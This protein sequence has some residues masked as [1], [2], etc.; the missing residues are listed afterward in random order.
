MYYCPECGLQFEKPIKKYS[1][2]GFDSPPY[3]K[4]YCCPSCNGIDFFEKNTTHCRCCG[5]K[6]KQ[7]KIDYCSEACEKKGKK[8]W[9]KEMRRR[10]LFNSNPINRIVRDLKVYNKT[11]GTNYSYGQYVAIILPMEKRKN[12]E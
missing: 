3:E 10:K 5:A 6:L 7:G 9:I 12:A 8:L 11:H 4:I 1:T 2:H